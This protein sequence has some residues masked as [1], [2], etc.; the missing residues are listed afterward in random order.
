MGLILKKPPAAPWLKVR[1]FPLAIAVLLISL[2]QQHICLAI[3]HSD[4]IDPNKNFVLSEQE[5][6]LIQRLQPL[7]V[8]IDDHF[9]PLSSYDSRTGLSEGISVD[10]FRH[11]A[12][13]LGLKYQLLHD[14]QLSW[15]DKVELFKKQKIDLLMPVS[16]TDERAGY[17][18]FTTSFYSTY[19]GAI[20]NKTSNVRIKNT[21]DLARYKVGITKSSAIIPFISSFV[22]S[23]HLIHFENQKDLYQGVRSGQ[24]DVALQNKNVFQADRFNL[25][26]VDLVMPYTIVEN[27]RRYSYFLTR[28]EPHHTVA[29]IID[30]YLA[31][32]DYSRLISEY[33]RNE[34]ELILRYN[35]QKHQ[36]K[37][38]L[39]GTS[40]TLVLLLLLGS[41]YLNHRRFSA[42]LASTL[43]EVRQQKMKL[44]VSEEKYRG[45]FDNSRDA[46]MILEP[47]T[48]KFTSGNQAAFD[49]FCLGDRSG[50]LSHGPWEFSPKTQPDGRSS[51]KKS[52]EIMEI[53][54][55]DGYHLF[56]WTHRKINGD[57]FPAEVFLTRIEEEG[58]RVVLQATVRDI[59]DR[60]LA[61][62][63]LLESRKQL[64]DIIEFLPDATLAVDKDK[65]VIIWNR[66]I[67]EMTG[68]PAAEMIGKGDYAYTIPF[69]GEA[70]RQLMDMVFE[71]KDDVASLY[72]N[73]SHSGE[74][75]T[76]EAFC[77]ALYNNK[78][79]WLFLKA[80]PLRNQSGTIIGALESHR[81]IT[82]LK[83]AT[84]ELRESRKR[85]QA[86][87]DAYDGL[88]YI[89][90]QDYR[91]LF[92]NSK[93]IERTGHDATGEQCYKA[94]HDLDVVCPWCVNDRVFKGE[95]VKWELQSPK[96]GRWYYVVNT[97]ISND[98][99]TISKQ[100]MIQDITDRKQTEFENRRLEQQ[101]HHAQKLE[102]LGVLAGGIAHD[103]NNIL[104]VILGH[105]YLAGELSDS[106]LDY[107]AAFQKIETAGHRA[108]D[109][110]RQMLTYAGKS[111]IAQTHIN[112]KEMVD[113]V[114]AMLQAAIKKNVIID[115]YMPQ[116]LPAIKG[117]IS[118]I[119]QVVMNL[120]INAA[121]AIGDNNSSITILLT[122]EELEAE[123]MSTDAFGTVITAGLYI[124]LEVTDTGC[125]MDE[126]TQK[127]IFEPFY[128]TKSTGRGLGM[129]AICGII[130]SHGG[131]LYLKS[132]PG[133]GTT[134]KVY[135]P[136]ADT[137][138]FTETTPPTSESFVKES[139]TILLVEDEI[140]LREM[141]ID[142]LE[143]LGFQ[144]IS[145]QHGREALEIYRERGSEIDLILLDL[146]M[147]EMGGIEAYRELRERNRELPIIICS[148]YSIESVS[149][150]IGNDGNAC[151]M[152]KPYDPNK[153]RTVILRMLNPAPLAA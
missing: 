144:V 67:E 23:A 59:T 95:I 138:D 44:Q 109:L 48:W 73:I 112:L 26:F 52:R 110:C 2:L 58:N 5:K 126:D 45:L 139:G 99:G 84:F 146:I 137:S 14:A 93:L 83:M 17:G 151:F 140:V 132:T 7:R 94:L 66:A 97:P 13:Q 50:F 88:L 47:P 21:S 37:L 1:I 6:Q 102:S 33:E 79:A 24:V 121:E 104:T 92:M 74:I 116:S 63:K 111:P 53:A 152:H 8:M 34:D 12:A 64:T 15:S 30:R 19:Y 56:E 105:C 62:Q 54:L 42:K 127:R 25:G 18:I 131:A 133:V 11:V 87:V 31:G 78:G 129:S 142:L 150:A 29:A 28:A 85:Y 70:R 89:C 82:E 96:D 113:E 41:A 36:K 77:N 60:K 149:D 98:D 72:S 22:P 114:V 4:L 35:E 51:I 40:G 86:I 80:S 61:E 136:A 10:L 101:F 43:E 107:K 120:I 117:D 55:R 130:K 115:I 69:Y 3:D 38:L 81:D 141:G 75:Y 128:T 122:S 9:V 27:P 16:F 49:M 124:C 145:A 71:E 68:I 143:T 125:G 135:F 100:A 106:E 119:Q 103:F 39:Y 20:L 153:L 65:R 123:T 32:A 118:Q 91:I 108:A 148:G 134:F 57:E 90:S 76:A 147:P 46:L